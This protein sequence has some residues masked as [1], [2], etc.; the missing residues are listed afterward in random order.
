MP[1]K[2]ILDIDDETW[3]KVLKYKIDS[4]LRNNNEALV[5]LIKKGLQSLQPKRGLAAS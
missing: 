2:H 1:K 3:K 4:T 5:R